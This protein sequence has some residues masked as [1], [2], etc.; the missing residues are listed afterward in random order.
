[1]ENSHKAK[2]SCN[3]KRH[4]VQRLLAL[5]QSTAVPVKHL[6]FWKMSHHLE[7]KWSLQKP[8]VAGDAKLI[9]DTYS[10]IR[11][12]MWQ[13][14]NSAWDTLYFWSGCYIIIMIFWTRVHFQHVASLFSLQ[15]SD[16]HRLM[17][18]YT[19]TNNNNKRKLSH[20]KTTG[21][22]PVVYVHK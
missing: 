8:F 13:Q 14:D 16:V 15:N 5:W 6:N 20:T 12:F 10:A 19:Q 7:T 2:C 17:R 22:R 11:L 21:T 4:R 9:H 18:T 1:M 3:F